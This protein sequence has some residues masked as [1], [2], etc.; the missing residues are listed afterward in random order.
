MTNTQKQ[1]PQKGSQKFRAMQKSLSRILYKIVFLCLTLAVVS[2]ADGLVV[3]K[4]GGGVVL[5]ADSLSRVT[6]FRIDSRSTPLLAV[7]PSSPILAGYTPETGVVFY[8]LPSLTVASTHK[9]ELYASGVNDIAFSSDG[10]S[11]YLLSGELRSVVVL[12]LKTSE[13]SELL[14]VPGAG[15]Q[16]LSATA[17]GLLLNQGSVLSLIGGQADEGLLAQFRFPQDITAAQV[18]GERL[19]IGLRSVAGV[20][21]YQLPS[22][23]VLGFLP[24]EGEVKQLCALGKSKGFCLLN[25]AGALQAYDFST[26]APR[27]TF[28]GRYGLLLKG[29]AGDA[30]YAVDSQ[31]STIVS[32]DSRLGSELARVS[33]DS[34]SGHPVLFSGSVR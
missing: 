23:R 4:P 15:S 24:T 32:V 17:S 2:G 10:N 21:S 27:W 25:A 9:G 12:D 7:H 19:F 29:R 3:P 30:V 13:V 20:W 28:P 34:G 33:V 14:P 18:E 1:A 22:G 31:S 6:E 11:L 16:R 8:N 26:P 5:E